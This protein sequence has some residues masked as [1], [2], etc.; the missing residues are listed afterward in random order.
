MERFLN[1]ETLIKILCSFVLAT[2]SWSAK[3]KNTKLKYRLN[4]FDGHAAWAIQRRR[5]PDV[6]D[7]G[8]IE[9]PNLFWQD[10]V[11]RPDQTRK[12]CIPFLEYYHAKKEGPLYGNRA[13][14]WTIRKINVFSSSGTMKSAYRRICPMI[15]RI[16]AMIRIK[17]SK[18]QL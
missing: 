7:N 10:M 5:L 11:H 12:K 14:T 9:T 4:T 1:F 13:A 6:N 18:R 16:T 2:F 3:L 17:Q 8:D 15:K